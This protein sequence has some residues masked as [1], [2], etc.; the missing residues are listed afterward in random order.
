MTKDKRSFMQLHSE[1]DLKISSANTLIDLLHSFVIDVAES[2]GRLVRAEEIDISMVDQDQIDRINTV[3][4]GVNESRGDG[5]KSPLTI[6]NNCIQCSG[7]ASYIRKAF[8]MACLSYSSSA[9]KFQGEDY[10]REELLAK[11]QALV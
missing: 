5:A 11:R 3:L 7:N 6:N 1:S 10:T 9:V 2:V 4:Y 8:K